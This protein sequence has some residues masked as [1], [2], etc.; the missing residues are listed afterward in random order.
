MIRNIVVISDG[1]KYSK[2]YILS[3]TRNTSLISLTKSSKKGLRAIDRKTLVAISSAKSRPFLILHCG[4]APNF[5]LDFSRVLRLDMAAVIGKLTIIIGAGNFSFYCL[6][7]FII[8]WE[9]GLWFYLNI[10]FFLILVYN[11]I[12]FCWFDWICLFC[13]VLFGFSFDVILLIWFVIPD[14]WLKAFVIVYC[15]KFGDW[16]SVVFWKIPLLKFTSIAYRFC[17]DFS[18]ALILASM[19]VSCKL[20]MGRYWEIFFF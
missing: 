20:F 14:V 7:F 10:Y 17:L 11:F 9:L 6:C 1:Q 13:F 4:H 15:L 16:I 12:R 5:L 3:P 19:I 18:E 8:F 2:F